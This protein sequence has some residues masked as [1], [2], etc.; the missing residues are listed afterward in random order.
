M[1]KDIQPKVNNNCVVTCACGN[2]FVTISTLDS[3]SVDI[4]SA[5]HPFFTGQ[6]RFVDTEKRIDKFTRK[7]EMAT[8][9]KKQTQALKVAKKQKV[10]E[11]PV[12]KKTVRQILEDLRKKE[13]E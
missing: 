7:L 10:V 11:A 8:E 6:H 1:K 5:C 4:C 13:S 9:R 2:S 3:I 12:Q